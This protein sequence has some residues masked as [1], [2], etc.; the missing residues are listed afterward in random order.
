MPMVFI[1]THTNQYPKLF[2]V[3][4]LKIYHTISK[5]ANQEIH[6]IGT[7]CDCSPVTLQVSVLPHPLEKIQLNDAGS[8][9][10]VKEVLAKCVAGKLALY[11]STPAL[12]QTTK[13]IYKHCIICRSVIHQHL[14][15]ARHILPIIC[16]K[17]KQFK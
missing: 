1:L 8:V 6:F 7:I 3:E 12:K 10:I 13:S 11:N 2:K 15:P 4:G 16:M 5:Q 17:E 9:K 14:R